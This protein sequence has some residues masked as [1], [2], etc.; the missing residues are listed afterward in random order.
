LQ[1]KPQLQK[2]AGKSKVAERKRERSALFENLSSVKGATKKRSSVK[3]A[4]LMAS[5]QGITY[6]EDR[7]SI[8][9]PF[10]ILLL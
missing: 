10:F 5:K 9:R 2:N 4:T 6:L 1:K 3:G 8:N 7:L